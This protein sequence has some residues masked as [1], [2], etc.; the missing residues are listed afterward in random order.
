M[1][2]EIWADLVCPWGYIGKRRLERGV[3]SWN[4]E[5][6]EVVWRPFRIDPTAPAEAVPLDELLRDPLVDTALRACAPGLTPAQNRVRV[7]AVAR[8]A[9]LGPTWGAAWHVS[10]HDAH[11]LA[12]LALEHGGPGLQDAV[13]E[14]LFHAHFVAAEDIG[15]PG[16]L[17][18]IARDAGFADGGALLRDGAGESEVRE[19]VL[20][21]RA[22][23]VRTSPT[24]VVGG[25]ALAGAQEGGAVLDFA[26]AA[27]EAARREGR[28]V[29]EEVER[30]RQAEALLGAGDP[31][32]ALTLLG[33]LLAEHGG[34]RGVRLLAAR[35]H[36]RSAALV[37]AR[38]ILEELV[39][40]APDDGYAHRLLGSVLRRQGEGAAAE[41]H[42]RLAAALAPE[43]A[44]S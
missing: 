11:R 17:D 1:R 36:V 5:P 9:G 40:E 14:G 12:W 44:M 25:R 29:P 42:L 41:P 38:R 6:V 16:T 18:R 2:I 39:E 34:D 32:G 43:Y 21:G 13:V 10:S 37:S 3:D 4:G 22:V 27:A 24:F 23:G 28:A 8:E 30:F 33:P 20:R 31:L 26:A 19:L 7:G 35:C 15:A